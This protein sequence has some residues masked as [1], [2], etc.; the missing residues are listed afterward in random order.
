MRGDIRPTVTYLRLQWLRLVEMKPGAVSHNRVGFDCKKLGWTEWNY[1]T[2]H[3]DN[4]TQEEAKATYGERFW[5]HVRVHG[6]RLTDAGRRVI[7]EHDA[8]Q[9]RSRLNGRF[10]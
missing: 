4:I 5:E 10:S 3:G 7:E 6:E 8:E 2:R 9:Q 1:R